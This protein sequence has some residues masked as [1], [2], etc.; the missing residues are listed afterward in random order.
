[1]QENK[2]DVAML[3]VPRDVAKEMA[4]RVVALGIRGIWNFSPM[5]VLVSD[6][7][8]VVENVHLSDSLMVLGYRLSEQGQE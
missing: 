1:M 8:V 3:T 4:E 7:N 6:E 2:V 5:G